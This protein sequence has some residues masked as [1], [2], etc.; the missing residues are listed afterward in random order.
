MKVSAGAAVA[1]AGVAASARRME[2]VGVLSTSVPRGA[3]RA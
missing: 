1:A 3:H 2:R